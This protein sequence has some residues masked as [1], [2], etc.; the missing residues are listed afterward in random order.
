M[1]S[2]MRVPVVLSEQNPVTEAISPSPPAVQNTPD[3]TP[4]ITLR[5]T[6]MAVCVTATSNS[7]A[8]EQHICHACMSTRRLAGVA[9]AKAAVEPP[10]EGTT[11]TTHKCYLTP[12]SPT[13]TTQPSSQQAPLAAGHL[14]ARCCCGP[15]NSQQKQHKFNMT[16]SNTMTA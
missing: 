3:N 12:T 10:G 11:T 9:A 1:T 2:V 16:P 4:G 8:H 6:R 5:S 13:H 14:Q 7:I 15:N